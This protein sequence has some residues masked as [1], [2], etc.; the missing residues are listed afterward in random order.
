M[1]LK[2]VINSAAKIYLD[3]AGVTYINKIVEKSDADLKARRK[4][5]G[6][7]VSTSFGYKFYD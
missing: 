5:E 7:K 6:Q 1:N 3:F 4:K 2:K